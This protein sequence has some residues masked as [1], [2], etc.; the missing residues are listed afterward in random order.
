MIFLVFTRRG[1]DELASSMKATPTPVWVNPNVFSQEE[2]ERLRQA[3]SDISRFTEPIDRNDTAELAYAIDTIRLHHPGEI[4][5]VE[6]EAGPPL[7]EAS[8]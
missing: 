6:F 1:Y 8:E 2:L 7:D 4:V 3:G 5:W